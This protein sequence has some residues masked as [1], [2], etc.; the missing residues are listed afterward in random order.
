[1]LSL[2]NMEEYKNIL[3]AEFR[4]S[5][6]IYLYLYNFDMPD[7][8][9][10][11]TDSKRPRKRARKYGP[12]KPTPEIRRRYR[13]IDALE[14]LPTKNVRAQVLKPM[15]IDLYRD[16]KITQF[17]AVKNI[18]KSLNSKN[19]RSKDAFEKQ[20]AKHYFDKKP[21]KREKTKEAKQDLKVSNMEARL[22]NFKKYKVSENIV[23]RNVRATKKTAFKWVNE[24]VLEPDKGYLDFDLIKSQKDRIQ[25]MLETM[26]G[27]KMQLSIGY[28]FIWVTNGDIDTNHK[29]SSIYEIL[30]PNVITKRLTSAIDELWLRLTE[31]N[32][33][34]SGR[35]FYGLRRAIIKL[36]K[37]NPTRGSSYIP[38]PTRIANI[39]ACINI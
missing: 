2:F 28:D 26:D 10:P 33:G 9:T 1:M 34:P 8:H 29:H 35:A 4:N 17:T 37:Y 13:N 6:N 38:L 15:L 27:L 25:K 23:T 36:S 32:Q 7:E 20:L 30:T 16:K 3:N 14:E 31:E 24:I 21:T 5:K 18:I 19:K 12:E 39:Q 11:L 22:G